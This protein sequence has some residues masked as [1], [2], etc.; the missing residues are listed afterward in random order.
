MVRVPERRYNTPILFLVFLIAILTFYIIS[1][2]KKDIQ[3]REQLIASQQMEQQ[4]MEEEQRK[5]YQDLDG[6]GL[7]LREEQK[8][9]T[10]D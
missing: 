8:L 10:S 1:S 3:E 7:T 9:G 2:Q 6:D 4:R 5:L